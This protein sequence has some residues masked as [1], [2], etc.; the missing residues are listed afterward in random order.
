MIKGIEGCSGA[1]LMVLGMNIDISFRKS[2]DGARSE[3]MVSFLGASA[4]F[5]MGCKEISINVKNLP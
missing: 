4:Y 2:E 3:G 1:K 5:L